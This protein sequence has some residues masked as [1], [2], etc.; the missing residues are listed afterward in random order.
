VHTI[1]CVSATPA[2]LLL[3]YSSAQREFALSDE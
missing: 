3:G 1:R 2:E